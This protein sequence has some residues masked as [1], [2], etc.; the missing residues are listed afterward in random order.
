MSRS[1][2]SKAWTLLD[3]RERRNAFKVLA[4]MIVG[5][6][7]SAAM[8]GSVFPFLSVLSN[9]ALIRENAAL[10][11]L[12]RIGGFTSDYRFLV[13]LGMAA[14]AIILLSNLVL[15]LQTWAVVRYTQMRVHSISRRLLGHYLAQPYD[16]F[17]GRHSGDMSTNILGEAQLVVQQFLRPL[18]D[19]ISATLTV[20]AVVATLLIVDPLVASV[21][22]SM[23][24]G[25]YSGISAL[26]RQYVHRM[27]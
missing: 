4:V 21:T 8:V 5:A 26:T 13:A 14:I 19:L 16:F 24:V 20:L 1:S 9:P 15:I 18:A 7:A 22:I 11:S 27:G 3:P 2:I 12:Y 23:F 10:A 17:L 25:I 6:F